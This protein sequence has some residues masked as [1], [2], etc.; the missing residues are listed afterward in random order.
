MT[1]QIQEK[2]TVP[3]KKE[4]HEDD[5]RETRFIE[6]LALGLSPLKAGLKAGYAES[7]ARSTLYQK[8]NNP[9]F[10]SK[11]Q[12]YA[13]KLPET[14]TTLAKLRLP[15]LHKIEEKFYDKCENDPELFAR[16]SKIAERDYKLAGLLKEQV[17]TQILVPVQVAIQV[18]NVLDDQ[19]KVHDSQQKVS[20]VK[21]I[22]QQDDKDSD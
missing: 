17:Q 9:N 3:E 21:V 1:D 15:K 4:P 2:H 16:Y 6:Y 18:Q 19:Q 11:I 13:D 22:D 20:Q 8:F 5:E 7:Y 12:K 14:R 10:I